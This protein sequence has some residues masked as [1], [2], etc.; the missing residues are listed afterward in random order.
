M[1]S[2]YTVSFPNGS[3]LNVFYKWELVFLPYRLK[4]L[5]QEDLR[6]DVFQYFEKPRQY[7]LILAF[8]FQTLEPL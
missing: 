5:S 4:K 1:G 8:L 3:P 2:S 6:S 7:L